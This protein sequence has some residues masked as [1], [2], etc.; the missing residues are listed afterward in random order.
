MRTMLFSKVSVPN[1]TRQQCGM[2]SVKITCSNVLSHVHSQTSSDGSWGFG[3]LGPAILRRPLHGC[4]PTFPSWGYGGAAS[5]PAG[6]GAEPRREMDFYN[7]IL[8]IG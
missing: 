6:F 1:Q 2:C 7:N 4:V 3:A 5:P 8:K